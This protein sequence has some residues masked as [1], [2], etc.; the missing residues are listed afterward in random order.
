ML[1]LEIALSEEREK[2]REGLR[3]LSKLY[4][5]PATDAG[6]PPTHKY[7]LCGVSTSNH[8]TYVRRRAEPDLIEMDL[9]A[10]GTA[11][12]TDQWWKIEYSPSGSQQVNVV[13]RGPH[14]DRTTCSL[15]TILSN[16]K[17]HKPKC[18]LQPPKRPNAASWCTLA[19]QHWLNPAAHCQNLLK[20]D[21]PFP[22]IIITS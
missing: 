21:T 18:Y 13:V 19:K 5:K 14:S 12:D 10:D 17:S 1:T 20:S 8:I 22:L 9:D 3:E 6:Q 2:A 4:T 7:T 15:L 11:K 16:R